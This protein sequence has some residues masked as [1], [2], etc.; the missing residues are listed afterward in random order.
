[1]TDR[2]FFAGG[3]VRP[4]NLNSDSKDTL[5][6][7]QLTI[8]SRGS[9]LA[10]F[11]ANW[12][13]SQLEAAHSDLQVVIEIIKT[14]GD[15]FLDA[16]LSQIGGKG[17]FTKE[18]EEALLDGRIDLAVH[19][20]KDLPT[21][22]PGG[23]SL[24]AVSRRE[25][26][27]D[28]FLSNEYRSLGALPQGARVGTSSLRR[29]SQLLRLRSDLEVANLRGNLDTRIR[30][31]DE[32][33]YDAILLA[34]A[35]LDRL[36][37][38]HRIAERLSVQQ[39]CPAVGQGA[40]GIETREADAVT[41]SRLQCLHHPPTHSAVTAERAFLRRLGGGC[42][43]PIAGHAWIEES[44]LEMLGVVASTDGRQLFRDQASAP[45]E[46][47]AELGS[48]L[49]ERLLAGGARELLKALSP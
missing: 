22:L 30:K 48:Q 46:Q 12:V 8:G 33:Q 2:A 23:L 4:G 44:R 29:Q 49:A 31:L 47:A 16:P 43:V 9:K 37:Y 35:G 7:N 14:S 26:A 45:V 34:C 15:V 10:L 21:V 38:Q 20:L 27:R 39:L 24:A 18:I 1:M 13:K 42:Q 19:S 3:L 11:Q 28:A 17:L 40:L 6:S 36:G 5:A 25:D 41:R 32:K